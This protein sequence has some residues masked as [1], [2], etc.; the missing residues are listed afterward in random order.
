MKKLTNKCIVG[1]SLHIDNARYKNQ[2]RD[3]STGNV[4]HQV[5]DY[6][7]EVTE[8]KRRNSLKI[9]GPNFLVC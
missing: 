7:T 5:T 8:N 6:Q 4:G 1:Q 2:N 9:V 3:A